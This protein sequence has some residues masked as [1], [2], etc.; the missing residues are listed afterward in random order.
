MTSSMNPTNIKLQP[1]DTIGLIA[2]SDGLKR[3]RA[4][5]LETLIQRL[6]QLGLNVDTADTL[7]QRE[8]FFSGTPRERAAELNRLFADCKVKAIFDISGGE[9]ANQILDYIDY[10]VIKETRKPFFGWSDVSVLLNG[11]HARTGV[12]TGHYQLMNLVSADGELQTRRF[13][14]SLMEGQTDLFDFR[15]RWLRGR[16]MHGTVVG[17]NLRCFLKLAGTSYYPD[18][19]HAILFVESLSGRANRI[20][21]YLT[22]LHHLGVFRSCRGIIL[23]TFTEAEQHGDFPVIEQAIKELTCE[24]G[25]PIVKT[26]ELGHGTDGKCI[27]IG[28][29]LRLDGGEE[30][31]STGEPC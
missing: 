9:S 29:E 30:M 22:Q 4:A 5:K 6:N 28:R 8:G 10:E 23:G 19:Q 15:C 25:L 31:R 24:Q 20:L 11:I 18:P 1:G 7:F 3:E 12:P 17:G 2:C 26:D 27:M 21:S 16:T 14:L 13:R